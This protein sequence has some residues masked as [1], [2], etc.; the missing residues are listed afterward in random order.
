LS[1]SES[2]WDFVQQGV[3][4]T[5]LYPIEKMLNIKLKFKESM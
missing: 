5:F 1:Q 4:Y 3:S 2:G